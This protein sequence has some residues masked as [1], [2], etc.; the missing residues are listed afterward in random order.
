VDLEK[1]DGRR[2]GSRR[3]AVSIA[4]AAFLLSILFRITTWGDVFRGEIPRVPPFDDQYHALRIVRSALHFPEIIE[5]DPDRGVSGAYCPWTPLYDL[6]AGGFA[7]LLGGTTERGALARAVWFP[8]LTSSLFLAALSY[9]AIRRLGVLAGAAAAIALVFYAPLVWVSGLG[10]IDHHFLE[11]PLL[12]GVAAALGGTTRAA[13]LATGVRSGVF[14]GV[15]LALAL[16]VESA[17]LFA[18]TLVFLGLLLVPGRRALA[19]P[20]GSLGF[21][22]A[23]ALVAAYRIS[24]GPGFPDSEWFL[25]TPHAAA[26]GAAALALGVAAFLEWRGASPAASRPLAVLLGTASAAAIPGALA[27][28]ADGVRYFGGDRSLATIS[29]LRPLFFGSSTPL[30]DFLLFGGGGL[31]ALLFLEDAVRG[32]RADRRAQALLVLGYLLACLSSRRFLVAAV[33]LFILAGAA[34]VADRAKA[35]KRGVAVAAAGLLALPTLLGAWVTL[36]HPAPFEPP[37]TAGFERAARFISLD[38]DPSARVLAPFS[39]GHVFHR[40]GGH[41]VLIDP[42]GAMPDQRVFDDSIAATLM[43]RE[44]L[45]AA[46]CHSRRVRF[47]VL[48]NPFA[49]MPL[50]AETLGLPPSA[51][52]RPGKRP[53][54]PLSVTRLA[55]ATFWWRAYFDHGAALPPAGSRGAP[56]HNFRLVWSDAASSGFPAPYSGP[57]LQIWKLVDR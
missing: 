33:P 22:L 29:E 25:G 16:F 50:S 39:W 32:Q 47:I 24:R 6:A 14:L 21:G 35:S 51:F 55:Q 26:L 10:S 43:T 52:F 45:L 36:R 34:A 28:Y 44:R 42:F 40:L 37:E 49:R 30:A 17:F 46:W 41:P 53:D 19:L 56:F 7:R 13:S 23:A 31:V 2:E 3:L 11:A 57:A 5:F 38:P 27:A 20:A 54:D 8:V 18:A 15:V 4:A 48:E 1:G 12:L 9:G